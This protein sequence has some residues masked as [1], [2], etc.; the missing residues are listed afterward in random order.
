MTKAIGHLDLIICKESVEEEKKVPEKASNSRVLPL[1]GEASP[2]GALVER[3]WWLRSYR[4]LGCLS[5]T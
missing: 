5:C 3:G 1:L 4:T 2:P